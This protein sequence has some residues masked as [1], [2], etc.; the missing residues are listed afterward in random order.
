MLEPVGSA[1]PKVNIKLKAIQTSYGEKLAL[2][3]PAQG[4]PLPAFRWV[5]GPNI[6]KMVLF[7][8]DRTHWKCTPNGPKQK[9]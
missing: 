1:A 6:Q 2:V 8:F 3:C 4:M 7:Y 5:F 9:N